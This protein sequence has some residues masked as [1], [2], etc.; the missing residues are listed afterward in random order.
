[1]NILLQKDSMPTNTIKQGVCTTSLYPTQNTK[2]IAPPISAYII[3]AL[4]NEMNNV[5]MFFI[6]GF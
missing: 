2:E 5:R 4:M 3:N 1:M 6:C